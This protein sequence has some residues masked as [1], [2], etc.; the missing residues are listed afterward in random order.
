[1]KMEAAVQRYLKEIKIPIRLSCLDESGWPL[2]LSLW[3]LYDKGLL[4]CATPKRARVVAYLE[5]EPRCAF[6]IASDQ[7]P[8]CGV[9]G[10]A[11][12]TVE[13]AGGLEILERLLYRYLGSVD[14]PLAKKLLARPQPEVAICLEPQTIHTWNFNQR[15]RDSLPA[16]KPKPCP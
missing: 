7:P 5:L 3:Y 10:R 9:R 16:S 4:Y 14:N 8:Y 2:V 12:A 11:L 6:E 13:Q 15:M 1:M